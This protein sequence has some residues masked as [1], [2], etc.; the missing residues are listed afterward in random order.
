MEKVTIAAFGGSLRSKSYNGY[1]LKTASKNVPEGVDFRIA[2]IRNLPM[3]NTDEEENPS[4]AVVNF[5]NVL[6]DAD[7]I[8]VVTPEYNYSIPGFIKNAIDIASRPYSDNVLKGKH[9]AVMSASIGAFGGMRAQYHL[10]QVFVYLDMKQI[11]KP[12]VFINFAQDKFDPNGELR[13]EKSLLLIQELM[14]KLAAECRLSRNSL[15]V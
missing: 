15:P 13:D 10:R 6:R 8:L 7:G 3:Y 12:E 5:K 11:N 14:K 4:E 1:L 9:V 2:P